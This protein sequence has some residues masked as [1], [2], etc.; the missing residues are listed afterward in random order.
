MSKIQN[1]EKNIDQ[2]LENNVGSD[3]ILTRKKQIVNM[4]GRTVFARA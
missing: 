3:S 1:S 2:N 4:Q